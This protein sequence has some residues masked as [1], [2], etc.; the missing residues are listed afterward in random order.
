ML[1]E[2]IRV[3]FELADKLE[4][5]VNTYWNFYIVAA[6][7]TVGWLMSSRAPFSHNQ[8]VALSVAL[9]L[10]FMGNFLVMRA[11]TKRLVA[12]EHELNAL[13]AASDF[14]TQSL[15]SELSVCSLPLRLPVSYVLHVTVD[16]A[17]LF[18]VW[19]KVA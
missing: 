5:R 10:F 7:A 4:G 2:Q 14:E 19:S 6:I 13:A 1:N 15:K 16:I 17:I 12:L 11:A 3:V 8:S 9:A 18:A